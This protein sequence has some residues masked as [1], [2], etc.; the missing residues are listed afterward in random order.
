MKRDLDLIREI[1]LTIEND[2]SNRLSLH[3]FTSDPKQFPIISF[4]LELLLDAGSI[5][6]KPLKALGQRYTDFYIQ[7]LTNSGCDYLDS[8]RDNNIWNKTKDKLLSVGGSATLDIVKTVAI[9]I[10]K[11]ALGITI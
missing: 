2:T 5:V 4:H 3:S 11:T 8:V 10:T 1:L 6:A 9:G 7:R